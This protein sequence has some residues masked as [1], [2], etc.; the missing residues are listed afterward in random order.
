M[1]DG[2]VMDNH[3]L[4][5]ILGI[6]GLVVG[7]AGV[8]IWLAAQFVGFDDPGEPGGAFSWAVFGL[9][10]FSLAGVILLRVRHNAAHAGGGGSRWVR[11]GTVAAI[12][13]VLLM[14]LAA[15]PLFTDGDW[16]AY[17][18]ED[19]PLAPPALLAGLALAA[20]AQGL[21]RNLRAPA[22]DDAA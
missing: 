15:E 14:L 9:V 10:L 3:Q 11:W 4:D 7:L 8:G 16:G 2:G 13:C 1:M 20:C 6:G 12:V 5:R 18:T 22:N 21:R 19:F 17:I